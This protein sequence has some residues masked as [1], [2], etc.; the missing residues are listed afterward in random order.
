M[1]LIKCPECGK[2]VS[3][4]AK[5]CPHC[6]FPIEKYEKLDPDS[7]VTIE[8][9]NKDSA[10]VSLVLSIIGLML[11]IIG[12]PLIILAFLF[13]LKG[14]NSSYRE[15]AI[16]ANT[17]C[18]IGLLLTVICFGIMI[19]FY[20][21]IVNAIPNL[22]SA[23]DTSLD[24]LAF[25][26]NNLKNNT[27][28]DNESAAISNLRTLAVSEAVFQNI[29][30]FYTNL[31]GLETADL[32][33]AKLASGTKQGYTYLYGSLDDGQFTFSFNAN[34]VNYS[35]GTLFLYVDHTGVIRYSNYGQANENSE[36]ID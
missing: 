31:D 26:I 5:V 22:E 36:P 35:T 14:R 17:L 7:F 18:F 25:S 33:D 4:K 10:V 3:D 15:L 20:L 24:N 8:K 12:L 32:I 27:K 34:P 30:G 21:Q 23:M 9:D 28:S 16:A 19:L 1:A 29:N 2:D 6:G 11:P 13:A